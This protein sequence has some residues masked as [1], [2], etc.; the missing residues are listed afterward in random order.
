[1]ETARFRTL[2]LPMVLFGLN[3]ILFARVGHAA[4]LTCVLVSVVVCAHWWQRPT[5]RVVPR[6]IAQKIETLRNR[7]VPIF[8]RLV[9]IPITASE[10]TSYTLDKNTFTSV[11]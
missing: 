5:G 1:M 9:D 7:L 3:A 10:S 6:T 2:W 11:C 8:P 4:W